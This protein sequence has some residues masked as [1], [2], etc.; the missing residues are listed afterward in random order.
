MVESKKSVAEATQTNEHAANVAAEKEAAFK[1]KKAEAAKRFKENRKAEAEARVKN[2]AE[3]LKYLEEKKIQVSAPLTEWLKSMAN[4]VKAS[5]GV[6]NLFKTI[7]GDNAKVGDSVS[8]M[9]VFQKTF[10]SKAEIDRS[11]KAWAEKGIIVE[12]KQDA[13]MIKSTYTIKA[14]SK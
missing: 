6:S 10:K 3:L 1:A 5:S 11:V 14:L 8:L 12:F 4:P 9:D 7:F 13:D 2:A